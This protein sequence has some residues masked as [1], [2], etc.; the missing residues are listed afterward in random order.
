MLKKI[1]FLNIILYLAFFIILGRIYYLQV[2]EKDYYAAKLLKLTEKE[3][4]GDSMPRGRIYD[5]NMK[6]LEMGWKK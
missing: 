1:N 2:I 5:R 6:I 3:V 4:L